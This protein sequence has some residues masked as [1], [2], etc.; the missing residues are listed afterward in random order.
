MLHELP[1]KGGPSRPGAKRRQNAKSV[2]RENRERE[3]KM[4]LFSLW[5]QCPDGKRTEDD[6]L[7]FYG[8]MERAFPHLL[9]RQGGDPYRDLVSD[10]RGH[11]D[12]KKADR[13]S[14]TNIPTKRE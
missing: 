14:P 12:Y 6:I 7:A 9:R 8:E 11:V 1:I 10:L 5:H 3:R 2:K 13:R 4:Q